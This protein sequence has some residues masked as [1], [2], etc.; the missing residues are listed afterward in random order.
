MAHAGGLSPVGDGFAR[1]G[2]I[3]LLPLPMDEDGHE[4]GGPVGCDVVLYLGLQLPCDGDECRLAGTE[5]SLPPQTL[6]RH[7]RQLGTERLSHA[8]CRRCLRGALPVRTPA[9]HLPQEAAEGVV[10]V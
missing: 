1:V 4:C 7:L 9:P 2:D 5:P 3:P 8:L 10:D 6:F